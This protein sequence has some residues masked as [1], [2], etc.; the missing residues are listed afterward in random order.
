MGPT[1]DSKLTGADATAGIRALEATG[2]RHAVPVAG[3]Q[4]VWRQF[5]RGNPLVL[6]HGGHGN[7]L[8]WARNIDSL[9]R[10]RTLWVPDLP[11]YGDSSTPPQPTLEALLQALETSIDALLGPA[12]PLE[13]A[14]FSFGGLVAAHLAARSA[15]LPG[16]I[17]RLT[18]LGPGGH[19]GQRRPVG[20][21]LPWRDA[22]AAGNTEAL[23]RVMRHNLAM[24]M[25]HGPAADDPLALEIH[26][27]ACL[28]TRFRS[29]PISRGNSLA[30]A[31]AGFT[32]PTVMAWGEHDV[33]A[34][35]Q[36][37]A[38]Q[39]TQGHAHR[40]AQVVRGAGHWLAYQ[41]PVATHRLI[42]GP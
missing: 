33:T 27:R 17:Q 42:V 30:D 21:L 19:G 7:W 15:K 25:L 10:H 31:L 37:L 28:A 3:G 2:Q 13:L 29:K 36:T 24:H 40:R 1:P 39:W 34:D 22:A 6:L 5:G 23:A 11:G 26:T 41:D 16:R 38:L 8:H 18:L 14:G 20:D 32:G 12:T 4:V 9:G 35:P